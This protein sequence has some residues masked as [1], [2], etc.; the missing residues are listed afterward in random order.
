MRKYLAYAAAVVMLA[1]ACGNGDDPGETDEAAPSEETSDESTSE[2][3]PSG[4]V[5][6]GE[7]VTITIWHNRD[8]YVPEDQYQALMDEHPNIEIVFDVVPWEEQLSSYMRTFATG[9]APDI[10]HLEHGVIP[11]LAEQGM[12]RDM[13][14]IR[15]WWEADDPEDFD[16]FL[17]ATWEALT[18]DGGMYGMALFPFTR[19]YNYRIDVLEEHGLDPPEY[20]SDV[21][22]IARTV[23]TDDLLGY[24][25]EG[26]RLAIPEKTMNM[27]QAMGGEFPD[28]VMQLDSEAGIA[29]LDFIQTLSREELIHPDTLAW[30]HS[31]MRTSFIQG[32]T[33]QNYM[34]AHMYPLT[35]ENYTYGEEWDFIPVLRREGAE[36]DA[37]Y[38]ANI[39]GYMLS[40]QSEAPMDALY[41]VYKYLAGPEQ[42]EP[43]AWDYAPVTRDSI[44]LQDHFEAEL[45]WWAGMMEARNEMVAFPANPQ[46]PAM[47]EVVHDARQAAISDPDRDTAEMAAEFQQQI[48]ELFE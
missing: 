44:Y 22:D 16:D 19:Q 7:D 12:V 2:E 29:L 37:T 30:D 34:G 32:D 28:G 20:W 36:D 4:E 23:Q 41:E 38:G 24:A 11:Q 9:D 14:Q 6:D 25:I 3:S 31:D 42:L 48:D 10:F 27:Y 26:S 40:S 45:P 18:W 15:D 5:A 39:F 17:P 13:S 8:D 47:Y 35:Q 1:T 46:M 43:I 21:L 33:A